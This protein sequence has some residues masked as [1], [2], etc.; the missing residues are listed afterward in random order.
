MS[1]LAWCELYLAFAALVRRFKMSLYETTYVVPVTSVPW[2]RLII[3][4]VISS[5]E[6]MEWRDYFTPV[7]VGTLEVTVEPRAE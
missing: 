7:L 5:A 6:D 2:A 4:V 3:V 1:S